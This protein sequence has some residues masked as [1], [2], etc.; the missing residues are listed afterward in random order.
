VV[1]DGETGLVV[2]QEDSEALA[3]ALLELLEDPTYARRL[4]TNARARVERHL[5]WDAVVD[6]MRP[7][8]ERAAATVGP[9][10]PRVPGRFRRLGDTRTQ[11]PIGRGT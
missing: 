4:G 10:P 8:L 1:L 5:N 7:E 6:R 3:G 2:P 11:Q 9:P